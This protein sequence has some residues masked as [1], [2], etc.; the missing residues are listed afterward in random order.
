MTESRDTL[1]D[2]KAKRPAAKPTICG[3]V[4]AAVLGLTGI[5][6]LGGIVCAVLFGEFGGL[7]VCLGGVGLA[8]LLTRRTRVT[9]VR[10]FLR[11][12]AVAA[13]LWPFIPHRSVEWSSP[14]PPAGFWVV[15]GLRTGHLMV[16]EI[17]SVFVAALVMWLAGSAVHYTRHRHDAA[18]LGAG[19]PGRDPTRS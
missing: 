3:V 16:F 19:C 9:G 13:F 14:W 1:P 11:A 5:V 4:G 17:V 15:T 10:I 8:W 12:F 6:V 7:A 18:E 2:S